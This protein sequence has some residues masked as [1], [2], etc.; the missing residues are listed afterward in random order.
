[1]GRLTDDMTLLRRNLD[2]SRDNRLAQQNARKSNVSAQLAGFAST[3]ARNGMRDAN[4]RVSFVTDNATKVSLMLNSFHRLHQEMGQQGRKDRAAFVNNVSK[5]TLE[6]LAGFN[7]DF[8][9]MAKRSAKVRTDFVANNSSDIAA[10]INAA[11][12]D[13]ADA[14]AVFFGTAISKKK[15]SIAIKTGSSEQPV[16]TEVMHASVSLSPHEKEFKHKADAAVSEH[17]E[18]N[19]TKK[20]FKLPGKF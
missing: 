2:S 4:A 12:H 5:K 14:H 11:A 8:K 19:K 20:P 10:F 18:D 7:A 1:M 3:R 16:L 15:S 9:S 13:R 17:T 6:L